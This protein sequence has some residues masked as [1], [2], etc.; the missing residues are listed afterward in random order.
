MSD[1]HDELQEPADQHPSPSS[2]G[3]A[4]VDAGGGEDGPSGCG[5]EDAPSAA[6]F[7]SSTRSVLALLSAVSRRELSEGTE[8]V[9]DYL[10]QRKPMEWET[11]S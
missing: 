10:V 1:G 6:G 4:G 8:V 9:D 2:R 5:W 7:C 3:V 11:R